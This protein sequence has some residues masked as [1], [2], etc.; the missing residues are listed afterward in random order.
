[1]SYVRVSVCFAD[2]RR[3][4]RVARHGDTL[5]IVVAHHA[6]LE[7]DEDRFAP[8][9][10]IGELGARPLPVYIARNAT[11]GGS[12]TPVVV[13]ERFVGLG[14]ESGADF[15]REA[16]RI[17]T[18]ANQHLLRI[19][20]VVVR[21]EDV[22]VFGDFIEGEKLGSLWR[23]DGTPSAATSGARAKPDERLPLEI[24]LRLLLDVL[25]GVSA[26]H[27]LRDA[28]QQPMKLMHG[29]LSP[30][31][32]LVGLDGVGRIL[33]AV[34]RRA[35]DVRAEAASLDYLAPEIHS[36]A[37]R[38]GRADVFSIGVL[39]WEALAGV[40]LSSKCDGPAGLFVRS[41][42]IVA[43]VLPESA[44]WAKGLL[45]VVAKAL[46]SAPEDRWQTAAAMAAEIRKAAGLKLAPASAATAFAKNRFGD[47]V[48]ARRAR[49]E[50]LGASVPTLLAT[51]VVTPPPI[52]ASLVAAASAPAPEGGIG[53]A[54][55][56]IA[57]VAPA[58]APASA[59]AP[60]PAPAPAP[61]PVPASVLAPPPALAL[62]PAPA[63]ASAAPIALDS[64]W[65]PEFPP[66]VLSDRPPPAP[67]PIPTFGG[68]VAGPMS[69]PPTPSEIPP[70]FDEPFAFDDLEEPRAAEPVEH[71]PAEVI[72][73][74][75]GPAAEENYAL[76]G[77]RRRRILFGG[78]A[79]CVVV[80]SALAFLGLHRRA[81]TTA[82]AAA[83]VAV[84][85][86][87]PTDPAPTA[88]AS[89]PEPT[90]MAM[91]PPAASSSATT[92]TPRA[93]PAP[94]GKASRPAPSHPKPTPARATNH[95]KP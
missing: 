43:P 46:A 18:L 61:A 91:T 32:I 50:S 52:P 45:P 33:H 24:T 62:A 57:L 83:P 64:L 90:V 55:P 19:R 78:A 25:T 17:S 26:L 53:S 4:Y 13:A 48:K 21:G 92:A 31:T 67:P 27:V 22:V 72:A 37:S 35:P 44:P 12:R 28:R 39:L 84:A 87:A 89:S 16:R 94:K 60:V 47:R 76:P 56:P 71:A 49:I 79:A 1:M 95:P 51:T 23:L 20:E 81:E 2:A 85:P 77:R 54:R 93:K 65:P 38:D 14:T 88:T 10:V 75:F 6:R 74:R 34:A 42:P 29:E 36:N 8:Y 3:R 86:S 69:A 9:K 63:P 11:P 58:P 15:R 30:A 70:V 59:R 41:E 73:A 7:L 66:L 5:H 40:P 80:V 82:P 68:A